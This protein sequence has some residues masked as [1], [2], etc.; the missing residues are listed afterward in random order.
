MMNK[1]NNLRIVL[2]ALALCTTAIVYGQT[3]S[4]NQNYVMTKQVFIEGQ[5]T[6][7]A[8]TSL[9]SSSQASNIQYFD[10]LGRLIQGVQYNAGVNSKD[11]ITPYEYDAYGRQEKSYIQYANSASGAFRASAVSELINYRNNPT[12]PTISDAGAFPYAQS[13]FDDT[14][15][16][17]VLKQGAPGTPWQPSGTAT[18]LSDN[19]VKY[20]YGTNGA[21]EIH[22]F[23]GKPDGSVEF[24]GYY[25]A[26]TLSKLTT[27]DEDNN[28]SVT[29][30]DEF[31]RTI[32]NR[33]IVDGLN[34]DTYYVYDEL[35]R[36]HTVFQP[37]GF[38]LV[39]SDAVGSIAYANAVVE[40]NN[41]VTFPNGN[42]GVSHQGNDFQQSPGNIVYRTGGSVTLSPGFSFSAENGETFSILQSDAAIP[43]ISID[44]IL[45]DFAFR[46]KY[47]ERGRVV[48]K[49]V[50]GGGWTYMICDNRNRLRMTQDANQRSDDQWMFYKYDAFDRVVQRGLYTTSASVASLQSSIDADTDLFES[51]GNS[52]K[53][54]TNA[55][56]PTAISLVDLV[57]VSLYD[58]Y[59]K[60]TG[61]YAFNHPYETEYLENPVGLQTGGETKVLG[62]NQW[63]KSVMYYDHKYRVLQVTSDNHIGSYTRVSSEYNF[64]GWITRVRTEHVTPEEN[65]TINERFTYDEMGRMLNHYHQMGSSPEELIASNSYNDLG[66]LV[67]KDLH[68]GEQ[69]MDY[70]YN[71][72]GWLKS[73]NDS[74]L[75]DASETNKD[76]FGFELLYDQV[77]GALSNT[78]LFNGNI[79]AMKWSDH[80]AV[81]ASNSRAFKYGYDQLNRLKSANHF[82]NNTGV[83]QYSV[84]DLSYDM[85]GNI[86]KL[87]R[88]GTSGAAMDDLN[89]TYSGN[90]LLSVSDAGDNEGFLDG[91][92][93]GNDYGYDANG[94]M[95]YDLNKGIQT[96]ANPEKLTNG[97]FSAGGSNWTIVKDDYN[98]VLFNAGELQLRDDNEV[99]QNTEV[100]QLNVLQPGE[101]YDVE[102]TVTSNWTTKYARFNSGTGGSAFHDVYGTGTFNFTITAEQ[103]YFS[104]LF[105]SGNSTFIDNISVKPAKPLGISYNH[106]NLP[107][108]VK[109][110]EDNYLTYLYD[111]NGNKLRQEVYA[112]GSLM[113]T[114]DYVGGFIYEDLN[115]G[116]GRDLQLIQH[117]EGRIVPKNNDWDYQYHLKDHLGNVRLTFSTKTEN[118]TRT[119][120]FEDA[121]LATESDEFGNVDTPNRVNH[122]STTNTGK[123]FR[124]NNATPA[125]PFAV[126]SVNEG[127]TLSL[128]ASAYYEGGSGYSNS[129][130]AASMESA[131]ESAF[132]TSQ[133]LVEGGVTST[134]INS[135]VAAAIA[136][137]G[138]GGSSNDNVPGAYL[139]YLV[140]D[141][142]MNYQGIAGF[143]QISSAASFSEETISLN[144]VVLDRAGYVIA[145]LSNESNSTNYVYFDNFTVYHG[146][147]N[148]VQTDDYYPFGLTFN[149]SVR[150]AAKPQR[151][152]LSGNEKLEDWGVGVFDFNARMYDAGIGRFMAIDPLANKMNSWNPYHYSYNNP[153]RYTDASGLYPDEMTEEENRPRAGQMVTYSNASISVG[154]SGITVSGTVSS[155]GGS[156]S[157][158]TVH[159]GTDPENKPQTKPGVQGFTDQQTGGI[160]LNKYSGAE[161]YVLA[162]AGV[163]GTI[164]RVYG[165]TLIPIAEVIYSRARTKIGGVESIEEF[166]RSDSD[167]KVRYQ[168]E[169]GGATTAFGVPVGFNY[170]NVFEARTELGILDGNYSYDQSEFSFGFGPL[171]IKGQWGTEGGSLF[172]GGS[173][174]G[175]FGGGA[176]FGGELFAGWLFD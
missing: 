169:F 57:S 171:I 174:G 28:T 107:T 148:I 123:A 55:T 66:E 137:L 29:F 61:T 3:P 22:K 160:S 133:T 119:A 156:R 128:S 74:Q 144:N 146:K 114:T 83:N 153:L 147:T 67:E 129:L 138:V 102:V 40:A 65:I 81:G 36:L 159:S 149:E 139:N 135:G 173:L 100:R 33:K 16:N 64:P 93:S 26:G 1:V 111:A 23:I 142:E 62:T 41:T 110:D 48:E 6:Q 58:D 44:Q 125:G 162:G 76:L 39:K 9:P 47:D 89:Y 166:R 31:D 75:S 109:K 5:K 30:S 59:D 103:T 130:S 176:I 54:Y 136:A 175:T 170:K 38:K 8:V 126:I 71:V 49:Y 140:F 63:I 122:P 154:R 14:P 60:F 152:L 72:R 85:N 168:R 96:E 21:A 70:R 134:Q 19:T 141:N 69:S 27:Y 155:K 34:H 13:V 37:E 50:P 164:N 18:N 43:Q 24:M 172:L 53:Y 78:A 88:F 32:I 90:R 132:Q 35:Q 46:Y 108:L 52:L 82:A 98:L 118:Y 117:S 17:R 163:A 124:L 121:N 25:G 167:N 106:L 12:D 80:A 92:T 68:G 120:T 42:P 91:N 94:N 158:S 56:F 127:D 15:L 97:D 95:A 11:I 99:N 112:A 145:Y 51:R 73:I 10:G 45:N 105:E 87:K 104:I 116:N 131:L 79:S 157:T 86:Q 150:T 101:S 143:T 4:S 161:G 84:T 7:S 151:F 113:K 115:D 165:A 77:D 2:F 20:A